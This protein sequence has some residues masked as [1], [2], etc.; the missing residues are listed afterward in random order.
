[1]LLLDST[2]K[3]T[4]QRLRIPLF[5]GLTMNH[6]AA[7]FSFRLAEKENTD[8]LHFILERK[9]RVICSRYPAFTSSRAKFMSDGDPT[10]FLAA[11]RMWVAIM[12]LLCF[13]HVQKA[14]LKA[15]KKNT[16]DCTTK[17][18]VHVAI[19]DMHVGWRKP[20]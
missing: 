17:E 20:V 15:L 19:R 1:M 2:G 16:S 11:K 6:T 9:S 13:W 10:V 7:L 14:M 18:E 12:W 4:W 8:A 5:W 3:V